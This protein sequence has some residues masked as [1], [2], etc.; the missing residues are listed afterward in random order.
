AQDIL[1]LMNPFRAS[2]KRKHIPVKVEPMA[3]VIDL[4]S[5]PHWKVKTEPAPAPLREI[6]LAFGPIKEGLTYDSLAEGIAA[7]NQAQEVLGHKWILAQSVKDANGVLKKRTLRCNRY[8]DPKESH[9]MDIDPS[10]HRQGNSGRTNC[11]A[12]VNICRMGLRWRIT[13][14]DATHN[15]DRSIPE[16]GTAQRPPTA[17]QR[18][19]VARFADGFSRTQVGEILNSQFPNNTLEPRQIGNMRNGARRE[20]HAVMDELGGDINSI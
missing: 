11:K 18:L 19:V 16:G 17:E 10:D 8:Q 14:I 5:P 20:A 7:V 2:V 6:V 4:V 15:H 1:E 3:L 12:H 9:L 13:T